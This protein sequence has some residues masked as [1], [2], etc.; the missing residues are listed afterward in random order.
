MAQLT[1]ERPNPEIE[2]S[3]VATTQVRTAPT[4]TTPT[5]SSYAEAEAYAGVLDRASLRKTPGLYRRAWRIFH[6]NKFAM[7][8]AVVLTL[9][10]IFALSAGLISTYVTHFTPQENHL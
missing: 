1:S 2:D 3:A 10:V 4:R 7:T 9:I 6:A 5:L 8:A